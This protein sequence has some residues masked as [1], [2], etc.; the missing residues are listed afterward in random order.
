VRSIGQAG[1]SDHDS[2]ATSTSF[3]LNAPRLLVV[4]DNVLNV[5]LVK[6]VIG[7]EACTIESAP[8][9]AQAL[10]RIHSFHP[11]LIL[12]DIQMP[13]M[14]GLELTRRI[15]ADPA[16]RDIVVL[17]FTAYAMKGDEEKMR[18]AGCDGYVSKPI[19]VETFSREVLSYLGPRGRP[20]AVP[21]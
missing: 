8:D 6:F 20:V 4:D 16:T 19:N 9:A 11:D 17:A 18:E 13:G 14:N 21:A 7:A 15:K 12:M 1:V 2:P 5:E 10:L 3:R